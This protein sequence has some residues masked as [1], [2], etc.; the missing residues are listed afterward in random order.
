MERDLCGG[1]FL[2]LLYILGSP[3]KELRLLTVARFWSPPSW[4]GWWGRWGFWLYMPPLLLHRH[5]FDIAQL[6]EAD[7][8]FFRDFIARLFSKWLAFQF[9]DIHLFCHL[10]SYL[11]KRM[12]FFSPTGRNILPLLYV[13]RENIQRE[14]TQ[15]KSGCFDNNGTGV[16]GEKKKK[17]CPSKSWSRE[18]R[19][20]DKG[21]GVHPYEWRDCKLKQ[22]H[23]HNI[24]EYNHHFSLYDLEEETWKK[25]CFFSV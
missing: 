13:T 15:Q 2:F 7:W 17:K 9:W 23:V 18:S 6:R 21:E 10:H 11:R 25:T 3:S 19:K 1:S 20:E 24:Q 22:T 12:F 5:H 16:G 14:R 4:A 8:T